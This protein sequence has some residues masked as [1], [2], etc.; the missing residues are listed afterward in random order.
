MNRVFVVLVCLQACFNTEPAT[1]L[2]GNEGSAAPA[3]FPEQKVEYK[4]CVDGPGWCIPPSPDMACPIIVREHPGRRVIKKVLPEY[5]EE[6]LIAGIEGEVS[7]EAYVDE[8]GLVERACAY[9]GPQALRES[10]AKAV[11]QWEYIAMRGSG[12]EGTAITCN[13]IIDTEDS[14]ENSEI[15]ETSESKN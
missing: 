1:N 11:V 8:F 9:D 7:V 12:Y 6:A 14:S 15:S 10:A 3:L 4:V 2:D 13:L 5:P